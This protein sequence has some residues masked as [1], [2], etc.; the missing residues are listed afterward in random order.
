MIR[1]K[2]GS[3]LWLSFIL[4][5]LLGFTISGI[6]FQWLSQH[7]LLAEARQEIKTQAQLVAATLAKNPLND[8]ANIGNLLI[9]R[10]QLKVAGRWLDVKIMVS[11]QMGRVVYSNLSAEERQA[12]LQARA[13][14][15]FGQD[16]VSETFSIASESGAEKGS[17]L[18]FSKLTDVIKINAL[19]RRTQF[20]SFMIAGIFA[21]LLAWRMERSLTKPIKNLLQ[22]MNDFNIKGSL[23]E[24]DI[25]AGDEIGALAQ[26]FTAMAGKLKFYD[27]R[28]QAFLQNTSHELKT[29]LMS[30][31]GY[32]EAIKDGVV[33]GGE[34][35]RSLD[36]IIEESRRLKR[37]VEDIIYLTRL[38]SLEEK[39]T[40]HRV[41]LAVIIARAVQILQPLAAE[42]DIKIE[43][44]KDFSQEGDFDQEK[45][46][47]AFINILGNGIRYAR[48]QV[49]VK[50]QIIEGGVEIY[51]RDD[52]AGLPLGEEEKIFGRFYK[53][54]NGGTGLG[55]AISLNIVL[56]HGGTISAG[57]NE[58][59][60]AVFKIFL[61]LYHPNQ[62]D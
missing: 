61:P 62:Q 50:G 25:P 47:R 17:V 36:I 48:H 39:F 7:Y 14:N 8:S 26:G 38:E 45:M 52:G 3:K 35:E 24:L 16:Y 22:S 5:L 42:R 21:L 2:I 9:E 59:G 34:V 57:N 60:G 49:S 11:N 13:D 18:I 23:P 27:Q 53:G 56:G 28:Q 12:L 19:A 1:M 58:G 40:F 51:I 20:F 31:Q 33:E 44:P 30:I 29:P 54:E 15:S 32:A 37:V 41:D 10:R 4:V 43:L 46:I 55:L 6:S